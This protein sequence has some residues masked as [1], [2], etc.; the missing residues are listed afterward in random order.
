MVQDLE[1]DYTSAFRHIEK[2]LKE[3]LNVSSADQYERLQKIGQGTFGEVFKVRHRVT[4]QCYALKRIR[5]EQEKEGVSVYVGL[6][7]LVPYNGY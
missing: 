7:A 3:V 6:M 5:M 4:R 1:S 2:T